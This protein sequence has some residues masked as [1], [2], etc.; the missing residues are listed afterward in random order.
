MG[1]CYT[2]TYLCAGGRKD[3]E[4]EQEKQRAQRIVARERALMNMKKRYI[5]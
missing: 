5:M 2:G 4:S 3:K 1:M